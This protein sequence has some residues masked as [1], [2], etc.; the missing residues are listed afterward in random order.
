MIG[1]INLLKQNLYLWRGVISKPEQVPN[2]DG[3]GVITVTVNNRVLQGDS[4]PQVPQ[5]YP[6]GM[7]S[8][9]ETNSDLIGGFLTGTYQHPFGLGIIPAFTSDDFRLINLEEGESALYSTKYSVR[10]ENGGCYFA[11]QVNTNYITPAVI[12]EWMKKIQIDII[13]EL[14][15]IVNNFQAQIKSVFDNHVHVSGG[16]GSNSSAPT[17]SFPSSS[18]PSDLTD[19]LDALQNDKIF[20]TDTG[21]PP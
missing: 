1:S 8:V 17:T 18:F 3:F 16:S 9:P 20:V 19:D 10:V 7:I 15:E 14:Q 6:Y 21:E 11:S 13:E 12:G 4:D 2:D 5:M